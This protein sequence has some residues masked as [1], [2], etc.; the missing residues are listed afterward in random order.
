MRWA[1]CWLRG[2]VGM[3]VKQL[4]VLQSISVFRITRH[5][6]RETTWA[7]NNRKHISQ[8]L[9][10]LFDAEEHC[11]IISTS[12]SNVRYVCTCNS[13]P[14]NNNYCNNKK[15]AVPNRKQAPVREKWRP[16]MSKRRRD[17]AEEETVLIIA[18][19]NVQE[20]LRRARRYEW[21]VYRG[22][23]KAVVHA[24]LM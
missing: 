11:C 2:V 4:N 14:F 7:Q 5:H 17:L 21:H 16:F 15:A 3:Y 10:G 8:S 23:W 19:Q 22:V 9:K 18:Q 13:F 6:S 1:D 12:I 24:M 20:V